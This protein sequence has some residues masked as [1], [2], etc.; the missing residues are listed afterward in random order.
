MSNA[1]AAEWSI[2]LVCD[3]VMGGLFAVLSFLPQIALLFFFFSILEDSGYMARIA[4]ILDKIFRKYG[5]SGRAFL[6]MIMGFGCSVPAMMNTRTLAT[7]NER[8]STIR[9]IPF[10]SCGA[11]LPIIL[12]VAGCVAELFGFA[13]PELITLGMYFLGVVVAL[14]LRAFDA[15]HDP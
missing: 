1:G 14:V 4:F 10:F 6:P 12:A 9:V 3:G 2:G 5:L 8:T 13:H 7:D 11:K 15:P